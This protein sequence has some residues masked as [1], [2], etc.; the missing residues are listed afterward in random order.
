[1][2]SDVSPRKKTSRKSQSTK[3]ETVKSVEIL[4]NFYE[5]LRQCTKDGGES[6]TEELKSMVAFIR[7]LPHAQLQVVAGAIFMLARDAPFDGIRSSFSDLL[8]NLK[9]NFHRSMPSILSA[10]FAFNP[11]VLKRDEEE[12]ELVRDV[13]KKSFLAHFRVPN[14]YKVLTWHPSYLDRFE[15]MMGS[16][17]CA[18]GPLCVTWRHY[19]AIMAASRHRCGYIAASHIF[20][21]VRSNG[22]DRWLRGADKAPPKLRKLLYINALLAHQPWMLEPKHIRDMTT[23]EHSWV[24]SELVHAL[25]LLV[26]FHSTSGLCFSL[27]I[28]PETDIARIFFRVAGNARKL[29][30][31]KVA[32]V[33]AREIVAND[34]EA[35]GRATSSTATS[36]IIAP[37]SSNVKYVVNSTDDGEG[38][39][40]RSALV[41]D[42]GELLSGEGANL[43]S[44][45][46]FEAA[47][48]NPGIVATFDSDT[49]RESLERK[50]EKSPG[51]ASSDAFAP[52]VE[53]Q[54]ILRKVLTKDL[55][56]LLREKSKKDIEQV[57]HS[58]ATDGAEDAVSTAKASTASLS[59][60]RSN[61]NGDGNEVALRATRSKELQASTLSGSPKRDGF[62]S[63]LRRFAGDFPMQY[64]D[65]FMASR[66]HKCSVLR[67][68]DYSWDTQCYAIVSRFF[69]ASADAIDD[70]FRE[71]YSLTYRTLGSSDDVDT[72]KYRQA[73]WHYAQSLLGVRNDDFDYRQINLILDVKLKVYIKKIVCAPETITKEDWE[74]S[75]V[76]TYSE[77]CHIALLATNARAQ[78]ALMYA[79]RA[80]HRMMI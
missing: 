62:S 3:R 72:T 54:R 35:F 24:L 26:I 31:T 56:K 44:I 53:S 70:M 75:D 64:V 51:S 16:L 14:L 65:F 39:V 20:H 71:I 58:A 23:G 32:R 7:E 22:D 6:K 10:F 67:V 80:L 30:V 73:V 45:V 29:P 50:L 2:F 11:S 33:S 66:A 55:D 13:F 28:L 59:P 76:L 15:G 68:Q 78:A 60:S 61:V 18:E 37:D 1:M 4:R 5:K 17:M 38:V 25:V 46:E 43:C 69:P 19:I 21:F 57:F 52:N 77:R 36:N 40:R 49:G 79:L 63:E 47:R 12:E 42:S 27:G 74:F 8:E 9:V 48:L 41:R 34:D